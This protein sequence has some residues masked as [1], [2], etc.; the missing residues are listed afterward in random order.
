[1]LQQPNSSSVFG[2]PILTQAQR[3]PGGGLLRSRNAYVSIP[4]PTDPIPYDYVF[5]NQPANVF[6]TTTKRFV[7]PQNGVY[8]VHVSAYV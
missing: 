4:A 2:V 1:M 8:Y 7:A 3:H 6:N 5:V